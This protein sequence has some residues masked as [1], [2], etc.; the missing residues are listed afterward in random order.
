MIDREKH[1][2]TMLSSTKRYMELYKRT[3]G[4]VQTNLKV[5]DIISK[6]LYK[7]RVSLSPQEEI[8]LER[9]YSKLQYN[10]RV[11]VCS[12]KLRLPFI[13]SDWDTLGPVDN[14]QRGSVIRSYQS[15]VSKSVETI[16]DEFKQGIFPEGVKYHT[17]EDAFKGTHFDALRAGRLTLAVDTH[18]EDIRIFDV[19]ENDITNAFRIYKEE[20]LILF[21]TKDIIADASLFL[22]FK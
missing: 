8:E 10:D 20:G 21:I 14:S 12:N 9:L 6:L 13:N 3:A 7:K 16:Y 11:I 22:K 5:L 2:D 1:I 15:N 4:Q 19:L 17:V 18:L